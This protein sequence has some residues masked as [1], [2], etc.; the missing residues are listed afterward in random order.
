MAAKARKTSHRV[1]QFDV[2]VTRRFPILREWQAETFYE[3]ETS[4]PQPTDLSTSALE[5]RDLLFLSGYMRS[6][7][8]Y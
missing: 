5:F 2:I 4:D 7:A 3:D 6:Y 1:P 8:S